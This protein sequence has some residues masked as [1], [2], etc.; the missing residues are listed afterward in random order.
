MGYC[1][2]CG[3][4]LDADAKFCSGCGT[5]VEGRP[6]VNERKIMYEGEIHKC[7]N[8][9][10]V[11]NSFMATCPTCSYEIRG[12]KV[13][14]AVQELS[15]KLEELEAERQEG[16][17]LKG[18]KQ[19]LASRVGVSAIDEKKISLI[20]NFAIP[21]TKE[22]ILEFVILAASNIDEQR[23]NDYADRTE[24]QKAI[25]DAWEAK[26]NQAYQ[27][28]KVSFDGTKEFQKI[29]Q[30]YEEKDRSIAKTKKRKVM[31]TTLMVVGIVAFLF[32]GYGA[33]FFLSSEDSRKVKTEND[34]LNGIVEEVYSALED[35]NY[36]LAR[37]K[38]ASL[39]FSGPDTE[40]AENA[41]IKWNETRAELLEVIES[42][43]KGKKNDSL[44]SDLPESVNTPVPTAT[45][46]PTP[47]PTNT[48]VP[49]A[50]ST[51]TPEPTNT[52]VP[53]ATSTPTPEPTN[54]PVPTATSTPTPEPTNTPVPTATST[55][56][57]E[58]DSV[59]LMFKE[60]YQEADFE[61]YNSPASENGLG[62]SRIYIRCILE[63][64]EILKADGTESILGYV[65][66]AGGNIWLVQL[67][68]IPLASKGQYDYIVGK[69]ILLRGV[70]S[71][72]S[73]V[74][75]MPVVVLDEILVLDTYET[76]YGMQKLLD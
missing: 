75:K 11:L 49:T 27:K 3:R 55:P 64:T 56:T 7:P 51:P 63:K 2:K 62:D 26:L 37:A 10:E 40:E 33:L 21:N 18:L 9:G 39:V 58:D 25:S 41:V 76:L 44:P 73:G 74:K 46:T 14:G 59:I 66:D 38:A 20:R 22:D 72:Y 67:H 31:I 28:A 43:E 34:R 68:V 60:G 70:Y 1:K 42:A 57:Q 32:I 48:P 17:G 36:V 50:T 35:N 61:R 4:E 19:T 71:G 30:I 15:D 69:D 52:P 45:S 47:E 53:T 29:Q 5:P 12:A 8:C 23:H 54:T 65:T 24:A 13:S 6:N 16:K